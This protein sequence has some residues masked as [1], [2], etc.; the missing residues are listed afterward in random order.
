MAK[1]KEETKEVAAKQ[2]TALAVPNGSWGS[3]NLAQDDILISKLLLM[4]GQS[5]LVQD[6]AANIGEV[7]DSVT[8][9][10][11]GGA[12][13]KDKKPIEL[14]GFHSTKTWVISEREV[15]KKAG[16]EKKF[17]FR[18]EIP[19]GPDNLGWEQEETING[20]EIRRDRNINFYC[21]KV[22]DV[23]EGNAIPVIVSFRRTG[24]MAGKKLTTMGQKL[25][26][27]NQPLAAQVFQL[28]VE[29]AEKDGS[30]YWKF[31]IVPGRKS[32]AA[33]LAEAFK[34]YTIVKQKPESVRVDDS[35]LREEATAA[36]VAGASVSDA[37]EDNIS[38]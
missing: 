8:K 22:A 36:P 16:E 10:V 33:E 24:Y 20:V 12:V 29:Q 23:K 14:I 27:F 30:K 25:K 34:W 13:G 37:G 3:E 9:E 26:A 21:L 5:K 28:G 38:Y 31:D 32:E 19:M 35:D 2:E 4:Q 11:V 18:Q 15:P 6:R 17:E 1:K 7:I